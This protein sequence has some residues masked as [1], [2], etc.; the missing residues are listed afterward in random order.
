MRRV[1]GR[2]HPGPSAWMI[3]RL[4]D[5]L[6]RIPPGVVVKKA[7]EVYHAG[8]C[9]SPRGDGRTTI[10]TCP[11]SRIFSSRTGRLTRFLRALSL[12]LPD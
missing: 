4:I 6:M 10:Q 3:E 8:S 9:V 11:P 12:P 2:L 7:L 1:R 5:N